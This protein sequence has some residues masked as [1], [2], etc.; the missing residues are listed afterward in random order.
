M[1]PPGAGKGTQSGLLAES[2]D[3]PH[4]ATGDILREA[5]SADTEL[6]REARR[7][8]DAGELVPDE[9][10]LGLV[11]EA[12]ADGTAREGF[13]LDGFPRTLPQADGLDRILES[14]G[15][16]LDAVVN[17]VVPEEELVRRLTGRRV[18]DACG[19][20]TNVALDPGGDDACAACGGELVQRSD[21]TE[22][23]VRRRLEV[24]EEQTRPV[25]QRYLGS[26]VPVL[27]VDG[28]GGVEE[29]NRRIRVRLER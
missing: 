15:S 21:D 13:I 5:R 26:P 4:Y 11:E 25:L 28:A 20:V 12:L 19:R 24:Y 29:V 23:T 1:G 10:V 22:E 27:E 6:G 3:V 8:M 7:Y 14:A 18:C 17:L 16:R 2:L 9:V